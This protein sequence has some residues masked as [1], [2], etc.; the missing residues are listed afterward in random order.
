MTNGPEP[1]ET[2]SGLP[3]RPRPV[4]PTPDEPRA[5]PPLPVPPGLPAGGAASGT[6]PSARNLG[7]TGRS[8]HHA[9]VLTVLGLYLLLLALL[10]DQLRLGNTQGFGYQQWAGVLLA[11]VLLLTGALLRIPTLAVIGLLTGSLTLLADYLGLGRS[12][13]FG[14]RQAIAAALGVLLL[15]TGCLRGRKP[16]G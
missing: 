5:T 9:A 1:R 7:A 10:A 6:V 16:V 3:E 2:Q 12:P 8:L 13:G 4:R 15:I 11:A 14:G